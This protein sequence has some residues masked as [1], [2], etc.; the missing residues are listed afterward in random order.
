MALLASILK[1]LLLIPTEIM[2]AQAIILI[3]ITLNF[4]LVCIAGCYFQDDL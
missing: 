2:N 1:N 4:I 3:G